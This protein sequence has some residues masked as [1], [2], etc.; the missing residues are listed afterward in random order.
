MEQVMDSF[1]TCAAHSVLMASPYVPPLMLLVLLHLS[2]PSSALSFTYHELGE[3]NAYLT[4][5]ASENRELVT[6]QLLGKTWKGLTHQGSAQPVTREVAL[7]LVDYVVENK[8]NNQD[9]AWLLDNARLSV[10]PSVNVDGS[11]ASIPGEC[12]GMVGDTNTNGVAINKNFPGAFER[13][14]GNGRTLE[15]ESAAV[16]RLERACPA[17]LSV[18]LFGGLLGVLYPYDDVPGPE[19]TWARGMDVA[20][21]R[22]V[23]EDMA[24][25][26]VSQLGAAQQCP[27]KPPVGEHGYASGADYSHVSGS[28]ADYTYAYEG[29]LA[30]SV[31][32]GCCKYDHAQRLRPTFDRHRTP[33][34]RMLRRAGNGVRGT[35]L[36]RRSEPI[37]RALLT[38]HNRTVGFRTNERGEFWR[39][40][41][42]GSYTLLASAD[43]YLPAAVD[44]QVV[45]KQATTLEVK[46]YSGY[47]Y[48]T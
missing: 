20:P 33:L 42:P 14:G 26:Y 47:R 37:A 46:L 24:R 30:L 16:L 1:G 21:D 2:A 18:L 5:L 17:V 11:D 36:N 28:L 44:F 9:V 4:R 13:G 10:V 15:P 7:Q 32:V 35:V 40:L 27:D 38:I 48:E 34:L 12:I 31:Y 25:E 6:L 8:Q 39:I 22:D 43:G 45:S 19:A 3:V 41:L 29:S 23:M